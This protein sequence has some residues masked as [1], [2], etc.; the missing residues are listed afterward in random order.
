MLCYI[1]IKKVTITAIQDVNI[2]INYEAQHFT[3]SETYDIMYISTN[4]NITF[5]QKCY[6]A[7]CRAVYR[8]FWSK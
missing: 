7:R 6:G 4:V 3:N 2:F 5:Y 1:E 8:V